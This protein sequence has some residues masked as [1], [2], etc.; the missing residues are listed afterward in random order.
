MEG[1]APGFVFHVAAGHE[2]Q[3]RIDALRETG[4]GG[5]VTPLR[6]VRRF[7]PL[8]DGKSLRDTSWRNIANGR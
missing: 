2:P 3:F 1:I 7:R 6:D 4:E 5:F 8:R